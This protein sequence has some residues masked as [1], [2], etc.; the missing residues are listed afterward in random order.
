[1]RKTSFDQDRIEDAGWGLITPVASDPNQVSARPDALA[2]LL[3]WRKRQ[4]YERY[5]ELEYR[6]EETAAA[7]IARHG[8]RPGFSDPEQLPYYLLIV[9]SPEKIPFS[10]QVGLSAS[11]AVGRLWFDE[12]RDYANYAGR[13][14]DVENRGASHERTATFFG[15]ANPDDPASNF[16]AQNLLRPLFERLQRETRD[17][18]LNLIEPVAATK[19][20][21]AQ[22]ISQERPPLLV[23]AGQGAAF[24]PDHAR[25]RVCQGGIVCQDWPGP[26][27]GVAELP[28]EYIF[29]GEDISADADLSGM[30]S[31]HMSDYSLGTPVRSEAQGNLFDDIPEL[32]RQPFI[33]N[34][35]QRMLAHGAL[36][37][38]GLADK[39]W[40][41]G[42]PNLQLF[43]PD[44]LV[45]AESFLR[46]LLG[47]STLGVAMQ[48]FRQ[49]A[50]E[51]ASQLAM[52]RE[53]AQF[54][55]SV[56]S[57]EMVTTWATLSTLNNL[58]IFGDPAVR[59]VPR[60]EAYAY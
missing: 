11:Y 43:T 40:N 16:I 24:P 21:L 5:K 14:L 29:T 19:A 58:L 48:P 47:G 30:I 39:F 46:N 12:S 26:K 55:K 28:Q 4:T 9:A 10:F 38:V 8:L 41:V 52:L 18:R 31:F 60:V 33:A 53:E 20:H 56:D 34:L 45:I 37:T 1:M 51:L 54:G 22:I 25:Q 42:F 59:L 36:A 27:S 2:P 6:P 3:D 35:P 17:W 57:Q 23:T 32:T 50:A 44:T 13:L 7:F 15:P 49:R